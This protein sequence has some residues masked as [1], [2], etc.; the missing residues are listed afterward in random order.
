MFCYCC[1]I[2]QSLIKYQCIFHDLPFS[3]RIE[4][5][6]LGAYRSWCSHLWCHCP[7]SCEETHCLML[8]VCVSA[9]GLWPTGST[10]LGWSKLIYRRR[11]RGT[12]LVSGMLSLS[13]SLTWPRWL[14]VAWTNFVVSSPALTEMFDSLSRG[15]PTPSTCCRRWRVWRPWTST[16]R[17]TYLLGEFY[18]RRYGSHPPKNSSGVH[19][20]KVSLLQK[21][22]GAIGESKS[23]GLNKK[24]KILLMCF[25]LALQIKLI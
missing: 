20:I 8:P 14:L 9:V 21:S 2:F 5:F 25:Y 7:V 12:L 13:L 23:V 24:S 3:I 11:L 17:P 16:R 15:A 22:K 6:F 19:N 18:T 10:E 4:F 1:Y